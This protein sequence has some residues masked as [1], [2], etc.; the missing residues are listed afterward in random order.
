MAANRAALFVAMALTPGF[1]SAVSAA[2][3]PSF[4]A[5]PCPAPMT[6]ARVACG[7][8]DVPENRA[9][10]GR[11]IPINVVVVHPPVPA[12]GAIPMFH[13]EGGP[14]IG[15]TPVAP[16][17]LGPGAAY[18]AARDIV[19]IDQRG[20]GASAPLHCDDERLRAAW[21]DEFDPAGVE[22]CRKA[23]ESHA[24]LTQYST[25]NAAADI[26]DVRA[27]LRYERIDIWALS[28]GTELAQVYMK[29]YAARVHSAVLVGFV[30]IDLRQPL[31]HAINGER[32]LDL[33]FYE[34]A[35]DPSC[36]QTYPTLR[37][38]WTAVLHRLDS[39]PVPVEVK[40][41]TIQLRRG[42]FGELVRNMLGTASGQR[43][44]PALIHAAKGGDFTGFVQS[45][46][47]ASAPV[48]EGLYLSIVCSEAQPRIPVDVTPYTSSTFLGSYR[49]DQ[50]R[51]AC[52]H[53]PR[54][55]V[56]ASFYSAPPDKGTPVLV[57]S[58]SMDH[59]ATPDW[60]WEFCRTLTRCTFASIPDM[61]HGPFDLDRWTGGEC[62]DRIAV[63]FLSDPAHPDLSCIARMR[64]PAFK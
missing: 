21:D 26:D 55:P 19:L 22:A 51:A 18:G 35:R 60:G 1:V 27:A 23:L 38:D 45:N 44:V 41:R 33:L 11:T 62:F 16:F 56:P 34:C 10:P 59:V 6:N 37:N 8:V 49:V 32:T 42:P 54:F 7:T 31:F 2:P 36:G 14:G 40:G 25:E 50:E 58:G 47:G 3:A 28:Y 20:T 5:K 17:Y 53:W 52:A 64:P 13:L 4:V 24:D 39:G 57:V 63:G 15:A 61:G 29:R 46:A 48:A 43:A 12:K 9:A 30:P